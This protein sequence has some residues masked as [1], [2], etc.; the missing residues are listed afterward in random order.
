LKAESFLEH[1]R[2]YQPA[3]T[4]FSAFMIA[5]SFLYNSGLNSTPQALQLAAGLI[6]FGGFYGILWIIFLSAFP[7]QN[8]Q[9]YETI[10]HV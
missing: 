3:L 8:A 4:V 2:N 7:L 9:I 6:F 1:L 10:R 5:G